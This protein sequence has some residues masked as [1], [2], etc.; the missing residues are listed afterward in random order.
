MKTISLSIFHAE[1][2]SYISIIYARA[3]DLF[4]LERGH[5]LTLG[6]THRNYTL[7]RW[8]RPGDWFEIKG[9]CFHCLK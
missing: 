2:D 6:S 5:S 7:L 4:P 9:I 1:L 3:T 8:V